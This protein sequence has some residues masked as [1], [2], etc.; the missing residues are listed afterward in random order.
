MRSPIA[1]SYAGG[2]WNG[3]FSCW[4]NKSSC[5]LA[6]RRRDPA[7][8]NPEVERINGNATRADVAAPREPSKRRVNLIMIEAGNNDGVIH[9]HSF[10]ERLHEHTI[11]FLQACFSSR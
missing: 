4:A 9:V 2:Q 10:N 11:A 1:I 7:K 5:Y 8:I 6:T 3:R